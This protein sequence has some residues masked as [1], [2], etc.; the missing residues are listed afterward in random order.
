M[1]GLRLFV[2]ECEELSF[3]FASYP[4]R[5]YRPRDPRLPVLSFELGI[6][7]E[8]RALAFGVYRTQRHQRARGR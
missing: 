1:S 4:E 8:D 2:P 6:E 5:T 7:A 3:D